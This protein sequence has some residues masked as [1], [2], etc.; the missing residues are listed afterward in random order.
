MPDWILYFIEDIREIWASITFADIAKAGFMSIWAVLLFLPL[1][2]IDRKD[3][4]SLL[5]YALFM[6]F[7]GVTLVIVIPMKYVGSSYSL[8]DQVLLVVIM[9]AI[10]MSRWSFLADK[11]NKDKELVEIDFNDT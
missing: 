9:I 11:D 5:M 8:K 2:G 4:S 7:A 3:A 1:R 10:A 6:I